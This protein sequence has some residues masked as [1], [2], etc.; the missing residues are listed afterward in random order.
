MESFERQPRQFHP[1]PGGKGARIDDAPKAPSAWGG[2]F[3]EGSVL[4]PPV[5]RGDPCSTAS[6][7]A[8]AVGTGSPL[9]E[10]R[11]GSRSAAEEEP[12]QIEHREAASGDG[13]I[14]RFATTRTRDRARPGQGEAARAVPDRVRT[15]REEDQ[16]RGLCRTGATSARAFPLYQVNR[17]D[18]AASARVRVSARRMS[19]FWIVSDGQPAKERK[20]NRKRKKESMEARAVSQKQGG[21][22]WFLGSAARKA[23]SLTAPPNR[24]ARDHGWDLSARARSGTAGTA[25]PAGG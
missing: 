12:V 7:P 22:H 6:P 11:T 10:N 14:W 8:L 18:R 24:P 17:S 15:R 23:H 1:L 25:G 16:T 13:V 21:S 19:G 9:K 20:T 3:C 2:L 4:A 5:K